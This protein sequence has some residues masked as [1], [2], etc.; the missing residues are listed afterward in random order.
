MPLAEHEEEDLESDSDA[1]VDAERRGVASPGGGMGRPAHMAHP[2]RTARS[3]LDVR[4]TQKSPS[5]WA[6]AKV[7]H[8]ADAAGGVTPR[9]RRRR[10]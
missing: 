5:S 3:T 2:L 6:G 9:P 7:A 4:R 8:V 10:R 1:E